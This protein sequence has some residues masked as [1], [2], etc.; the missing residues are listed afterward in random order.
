[1]FPNVN[2]E[3]RNGKESQINKCISVF[4]EASLVDKAV[5]ALSLFLPRCEFKAG[6]NEADVLALW[7]ESLTSPEAYT[8]TVKCGR[9]VIEYNSY[10][11]LRNAIATFSLLVKERDG[12]VVV[13]DVE[14]NDC[15]V[16]SHR[17][18][19]LD[20]A[21]G[22]V[23]LGQLLDDMVLIA[24]SRH[25][26]LHLHLADAKGVAV[27]MDSF[28]EE[29]RIPDYYTKAQVSEIVR[30]ADVL[31]LE[32]IPEIDM[33]AH[34]TRL[35]TV[36]PELK[37]DTDARPQCLWTVCAGEERVYELYRKVLLEIAQMFP[38][39]R[40]LHIGGDELEFSDLPTER[41][42]VCH[43]HECRK[44]KKK[45]EEEGIRDRQE[46]YYYFINRINGY[47]K[48][49]GKQTVMWSD[50]IDCTRP[51]ALSTD[52]LMQFWRV[53]AHGRGPHDGCSMQGQLDLG[54]KMINSFYWNTY[55][56]EEHYMNSRNLSSWRWDEIPETT[57][58]VK[59]Q[60]VGS[61]VCAWEYGNREMFKHYDYS[62]P[63]AIVLAGD[64]FWCGLKK[65][66]DTDTALDL[67]K[68]VLG[69]AVPD[70][71]NPFEAVGD[72]LPPRLD[73]PSY[74]ANVTLVKGKIQ[75]II[76]T[77]S[78]AS[79]YTAGDKTRAEIYKKCI[80]YTLDKK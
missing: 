32:I 17:G 39:G 2:Q 65:P 53:A 28:P 12:A 59:H 74:V 64:K 67:T 29:Y 71:F 49:C 22:T 14:I 43:W 11:G 10:L 20:I 30:L 38:T 73:E 61:E 19:M 79:L 34:S 78:D 75:E 69:A 58:S 36:L 62:L 15:P 24:K 44:C 7:R 41:R 77:L 42:R 55:L 23:P 60:I 56:D 63:S 18:V 33:P 54:Y 46:L 35:N 51:A 72:I 1:M 9:A 8:L 52:I 3:I 70:G 80:E 26:I 4:A 37:C 25:N 27:E 21:R 31:G 16:L 48:E 57:E 6:D 40:Y 5:E 68:A 47:V 76:D 66:Y 50:Q 45:M 13:P